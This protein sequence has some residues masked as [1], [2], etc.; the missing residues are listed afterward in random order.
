MHGPTRFRGIVRN[1]S[2]IP[3]LRERASQSR[4]ASKEM[5][6]QCDPACTPATEEQSAEEK[7]EETSL[8]EPEGAF[9]KP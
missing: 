5:E 2:N 3:E 4:G 7:C 1:T 8:M 9:L 6:T